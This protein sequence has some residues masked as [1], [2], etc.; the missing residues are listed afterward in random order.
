MWGWRGFGVGGFL[1]AGLKGKALWL[2]GS[3]F[4]GV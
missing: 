2:E 1:A 4:T 3:G